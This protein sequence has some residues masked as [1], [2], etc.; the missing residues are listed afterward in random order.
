MTK[1]LEVLTELVVEVAE[2]LVFSEAEE[3]DR[4]HDWTASDNY[5]VGIDLVAPIRAKLWISASEPV[6]EEWIE[7]VPELAESE[8]QV[9]ALLGEV[10]NTIA[11]R[12]EVSAAGDSS[13]SAV[14]L[15]ETGR[16]EAPCQPQSRHRGRL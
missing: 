13:P 15:P 10:A 3:S 6:L 14:G 4:A 5:W 16:G 9:A 7:M 11:G 8:A 12:L 1:Q 2:T